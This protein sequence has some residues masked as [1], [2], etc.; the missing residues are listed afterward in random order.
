VNFHSCILHFTDYSAVLNLV[1]LVR[2][3]SLV[4]V[5]VVFI[6]IK[7]QDIVSVLVQV[8]I[9]LMIEMANK[10]TITTTTKNISL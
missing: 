10:R 6:V 8:A 2:D 9:G 1:N 5:V 7:H 3:F 4:H